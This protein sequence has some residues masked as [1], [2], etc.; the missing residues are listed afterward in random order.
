MKRLLGLPVGSVC[1]TG[2]DGPAGGPGHDNHH[3]GG[4]C[5]SVSLRAHASPARYAPLIQSAFRSAAESCSSRPRDCLVT[6]EHIIDCR[7]V[8]GPAG[9]QSMWSTSVE[10]VARKCAWVRETSST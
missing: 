5:R 2:Y 3:R 10:A 7:S 9:T 4:R 1:A 6:V 8:S